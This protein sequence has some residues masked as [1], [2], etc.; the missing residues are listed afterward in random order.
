MRRRPPGGAAAAAVAAAGTQSRTHGNNGP[1]RTGLHRPAY[2]SICAL[3]AAIIARARAKAR[4]ARAARLAM[5]RGVGVACVGERHRKRA[6][7]VAD[8]RAERSGAR[9]CAAASLRVAVPAPV[10][11]SSCTQHPASRPAN[12]CHC[13][14]PKAAR[15]AQQS[16][17]PSDALGHSPGRMR[18][19]VWR[20]CPVM[21]LAGALCRR[22]RI[23]GE[24]NRRRT[25]C[26]RRRAAPPMPACTI[27]ALGRCRRQLTRWQ[28]PQ[29]QE[30]KS[31]GA[32][33]E[34]AAMARSRS[35]S[36]PD[37]RRRSRSR[38][39]A[40][41][42][43]RS[44]SRER[45]DDGRGARDRPGDYRGERADAHPHRWV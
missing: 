8:G 25:I 45:R 20:L 11:A 17:Q 26:V 24:R 28:H 35:R 44:R 22:C 23:L 32:R 30:A 4:A 14:G 27:L 3:Q 16:R 31:R 33:R 15:R 34:L 12:D 1:R 40:N 42:R 9:I 18:H 43:S 21:W 37:R 38:S 39:P 19:R 29:A 41:R 13:R 5:A 7:T 2:L 36:P 10:G 6:G